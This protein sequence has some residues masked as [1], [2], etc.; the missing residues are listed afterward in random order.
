VLELFV[1]RI[2]RTLPTAATVAVLTAVAL[3]VT[4]GGTFHSSD[5]LVGI[6][7]HPGLQGEI[8]LQHLVLQEV[9]EGRPFAEQSPDLINYPYG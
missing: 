6:D 2:G 8:F 4:A 9:L 5:R 1:G 7:D 3:W